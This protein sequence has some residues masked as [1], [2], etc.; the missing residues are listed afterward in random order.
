[1][2]KWG[3]LVLGVML[4]LQSCNEQPKSEEPLTHQMDNPAGMGSALPFLFSDGKSALLSWVEPA[5]DSLMAL[6]YSRLEGQTWSAPQVVVAGGDW[7][8][9]WADFPAISENQ[10][11]L[12][13]H[14]LKKSSEGTYS[15]D[16]KLNLKKTDEGQ[17]TT[18]LPLH[19]D[20]T[21]TE[22]GFVS[23]LPYENGFFITW[24]DGRNTI[25]NEVGKRGAMAVRAAKIDVDG[26]LIDEQ[27]LDART[28]DCCQTT[29]AITHNGPVVI[30]RDRSEDEIRDISI[31]RQVKGQWSA[32]K[33]IHEDGWQI[34]G[35]P[36]NGPKAAALGNR[37][38]VAWFTAANDR[39]A[40][41]LIFSEDGGATFDA[42]I[43]ISAINAIGRVDVLMLDEEN[44]F[45]SWMEADENGA[46][47][48][49]AKVNRN[50]TKGKIHAIA[51]LDASRKTG[52][53]QM[54]MVGDKIYFAW[55]HITE[56]KSKVRTAYVLKQYF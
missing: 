11:H 53:P 22:H 26:T 10:G 39:P 42:P 24:L 16:V 21:P 31:V 32:P 9:N 30:Y 54:E 5:D 52:F 33:S 51:P 47:L 12:L 49:A 4:C 36:V 43:Q 28:C 15:Y 25:E 45:V 19:T 37:L 23:S 34:K 3:C 27:E 35:C 7:F 29:A 8:V 56:E 18:D 20:N 38:A 50:G 48:N 55:T 14:I 46:V 13:S 41:N 17:W 6:K 2:R 1:M 40:V 44:A